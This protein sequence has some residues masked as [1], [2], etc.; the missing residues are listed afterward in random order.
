MPKW[1]VSALGFIAL[2]LLSFYCVSHHAHTIP[3][4]LKSR[5]EAA[6]MVAG[7][8][9]TGLEF[10]GRIATLSGFSDSPQVSTKAIQ[11]VS[12]VS[13]VFDVL[14]KISPGSHEAVESTQ[15][16]KKL[17]DVIVGK[18]VE[19]ATGSAD[20]TSNGK[21]VLDQMVALLKQFPNKPVEISGHT[22]G[23]G[24]HGLNITL[25][26]ERAESVR[27]YLIIQGI[28]ASRL[29]SAGHG[30]DNPVADNNTEEGRQ[31]N[32]RIEFHV[33]ETR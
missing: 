5:S 33:K 32:R 7:F 16:E 17:Q 30:P 20:L 14:T 12:S 18:V 15:L 8:S 10:D 29:F 9:T 6:L 1:I 3:I 13:G 2:A 25:S 19:F 23:E 27:K 26:K 31:K 11:A 24:N 28:Q 22:D 4:D 21:A